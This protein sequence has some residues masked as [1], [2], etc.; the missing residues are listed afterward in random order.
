[1]HAIIES[2]ILGNMSM[3]TSNQSKAPYQKE[4]KVLALTGSDRQ[5]FD[6]GDMFDD[7]SP[8]YMSSNMY[9]NVW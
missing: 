5:A 7:M 9:S 8:E 6:S 1:L 3:D 4:N 2:L